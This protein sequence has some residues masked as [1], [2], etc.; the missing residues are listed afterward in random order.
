MSDNSD[1]AVSPILEA[2]YRGDREAVD[3]LLES[4]P[5]LDVFEAAALGRTERVRELLDEDPALVDGWSVD[6]FMPLHL[7]AFFG[8][9]DTVSLLV[10]RG[11]PTDPVSRHEFIKATPL[12][13]AVAQEGAADLRTV[14]VLL[15]AGAPV[16]ATAEGGGTP[17]HSAAFNGDTAIVKALLDRGADPEARSGDGK[18]PL[19]LASDQGHGVVAGLLAAA[20]A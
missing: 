4:S 2:L 16:N 5:T 1:A 8:H 9:A 6:G 15:D 10:D 20:N 14:E 11:A 17:L 19:D 7:A 12:H 18:T 13:S 3:S